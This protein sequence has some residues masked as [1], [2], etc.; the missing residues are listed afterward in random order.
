MGCVAH[1][2]LLL[3]QCRLLLTATVHAHNAHC[4]CVKANMAEQRKVMRESACAGEGEAAP[5]APGR[6]LPEAGRCH[7]VL[8]LCLGAAEPPGSFIPAACHCRGQRAGCSACTAEWYCQEIKVQKEAWVDAW[9]QLKPPCSVIFR[10]PAA[11]GAKV[12]RCSL[13][14]MR[15]QTAL[16]RSS[17]PI[18]AVAVPEDS[19]SKLWCPGGFLYFQITPP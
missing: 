7:G 13:Q 5:P 19:L 10:Q 1:A 6:L 11:P 17:T 3:W 16:P 14:R 15:C 4:L 2:F 12:P 18:S 8:D 9:E